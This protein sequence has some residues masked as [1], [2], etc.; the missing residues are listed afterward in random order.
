MK[1]F[2]RNISLNFRVL[3]C[4]QDKPNQ[5]SSLSELQGI[6]LIESEKCETVLDF[7]RRFITKV[8]P[9][10]F[11][12]DSSNLDALYFWM[13]GFQI[14]KPF[15]SLMQLRYWLRDRTVPHLNRDSF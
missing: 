15:S 12:Q 6:S 13:Y 14:G 3:K 8:Y 11:R 10:F 5:V 9:A 4:F 7:T 2:L 1:P